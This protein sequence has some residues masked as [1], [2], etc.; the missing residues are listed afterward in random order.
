M[1]ANT[2]EAVRWISSRKKTDYSF[3]RF[4]EVC[5]RLGDPQNGLYIIHVAGTNGKGSTVNYLADLLM[6]QGFKVGTIT[7]PQYLTY[8]DRIRINGRNID[9]AS[10]LEIVNDNCGFFAQNGLSMYEMDY[11][12]MCFYFR[13][14]NVD[15]AIVETGI[16]GR[17]DP[18][19]VSDFT[20]LSII[21]SIGLDHT[22]LLGDTL[23]K[24]CHDK[25]G[26]I[27]EDSDVLCGKLSEECLEVVRQEAFKKNAHVYVLDDY[28]VLAQ[29]RFRFHEREY[30]VS[31]FASYQ[32]YNASVAIYALELTAK[33]KGF[34]IDYE[35]AKEALEKSLWHLRFEIVKENPRVILDGAH[36]IHGVEAMLE[37]F[38]CF[39]GSKCIV[40]SALRRKEYRKMA[41]L[42][43]GHCDR[44]I[45]TSFENSEAIGSRDMADYGVVEDYREAIE[46][47]MKN[48]DN[49]LI[50]GSLYFLSDVVSHIKFE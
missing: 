18:T 15:I 5:H 6:S 13:K 4:R 17:Y 42:L 27:K 29:R 41:E 25:C 12:I 3:E 2:E 33:R 19:N 24:I 31:S 36:N 20:K 30:T 37:S 1:F 48:Y 40:F 21:T 38:D 46:E 9:E 35:K 28:E 44:L 43:S 7:S 14:E 16:G 22:E 8:L 11:L 23:A 26:I 34:E 32:L 45:V 47:A 49:V 39:T 10:F 50:C